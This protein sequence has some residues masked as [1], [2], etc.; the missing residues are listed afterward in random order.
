M[1]YGQFLEDKYI[2]ELFSNKNNGVCIDVGAY[3][4]ITGS[5]SF[6]FEQNGWDCLCIEPIPDSF[7]KC[8][9]IRKNSVKYCISDKDKEDVEFTVFKLIGNNLSAISSLIPDDR[10]IDSHK[11][12]IQDT[13]K[14]LVQVRSLTSLLDELNF[15]EDIDFISI[16][17]ENTELDV[18]KGIDFNKYNIKMLVIEN[19]YNEPFCENYLIDYGYIKINRLAVNDFYIKKSMPKNFKIISAYYYIQNNI[20]LANVTNKINSLYSIF[21]LNQDHNT[22]IVSNSLFGDTIMY[23]T[24]TLY[25]NIETKHKNK[26]TLQFVEGSV[27]NWNNIETEIEIEYNKNKLSTL[28]DVSIGEIIDKYSI[29][30]LKKKYITNTISLSEIQKELF[31]FNKYNEIKNNYVFFYKILLHINENIWL[32]TDKIKQMD[33]NDSDP[34][35]ILKFALLSNNIF[36]N[37]QKRFR[38]KNYF[39]QLTDSNIN[40]QKSYNK[41]C[42]YIDIH[43]DETI[44]DKISEINYLFLEYDLLYFNMKYSTIITNIFMNPNK[45]FTESES[46]SNFDINVKIIKLNEYIIEDELRVTYD[47]EPIKYISGG[48]IGDFIYQ[49]SVINEKFYLTGRKGIVYIANTGDKFIFGLQKAYDDLF[50]IVSKQRY[51]YEFKMFNNET[52]DINLSIWRQNLEY[53]LNNN[54]SFYETHKFNYNVEWGNHPWIQC[55]TD[56]TWSNKIIISTSSRRFMTPEQILSFIEIIKDKIDECIFVSFEIKEWNFFCKEIGLDIPL[57]LINNF[58]ELAI[59][60]NSCKYAYLS[61]SSPQAFANS[62]HKEHICLLSYLRNTQTLSRYDVILANLT[63]KFAHLKLL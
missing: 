41:T 19:N 48:L 59:I 1:F 45:S 38:L 49:L 27:V 39:N 4:G 47:L 8:N 20:E 32:D 13:T 44:Y 51:I 53:T 36:I 10:L 34:D 3:D 18:L 50:N 5:N 43:D 11:H 26:I 56:Q 46:E 29:L 60:I 55:E 6:L 33:I 17:T 12:L 37:N 40:E 58:E 14:I 28:I 61:L 25:V 23:T 52:I 9:S 31:L 15:N 2:N 42:C 35:N 21:Q 24:K 30:E 62:L 54:Y 57:Y 7:D 63:H 16:D 22:F